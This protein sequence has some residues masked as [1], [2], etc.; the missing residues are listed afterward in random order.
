MNLKWNIHSIS[1]GAT[2]MF[3]RTQKKKAFS[4]LNKEK[5]SPKHSE[6]MESVFMLNYVTKQRQFWEREL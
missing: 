2:E 4:T 3:S 5:Y 1:V 6:V